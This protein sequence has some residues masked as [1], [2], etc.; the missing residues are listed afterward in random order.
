MNTTYK[1]QLEQALIHMAGITIYRNILNDEIVKKYSE[2]IHLLNGYSAAKSNANFSRLLNCYHEILSMLIYRYS[3]DHHMTG[4]LWKMHIIHL[5]LSDENPFSLACEKAKDFNLP[6]GL[7]KIVKMDLRHI[8]FLFNLDGDILQTIIKSKVPV[9]TLPAWVLRAY[10][11]FPPA[12]YAENEK[13]LAG[14]DTVH[15]LY[16]SENWELETDTLKTYYYQFGCGIFSQYKAFRWNQNDACG[17]LTGIDK[18]DPIRLSQL[19]SYERER[20]IVIKNTMQFIHGLPCNNVLLYGDR[21][22]GKSATVKA[23]LN[24]YADYRL[25]LIEVSKYHL[26]SLPQ[27]METLQKRGL[28]FILFIDD[29]SFE[30]DESSYRELKSI[31][32]G[33]IEVKPENVVIYA[34]SNRR[35]LIKEYFSERSV[36]DE[37]SSRDTM[38]EKLSLS[39]RFGITV[40]FS[41]PDKETYLQIVEGLAKKRGLDID[42]AVLR[43]EALKWEMRYNGRSPRTASQFINYLEGEL[44]PEK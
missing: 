1:K 3:E 9:D 5:L 22:T 39:D 2:L 38:Q 31:L 42:T 30:S 20:S 44:K 12:S 43:A 10:N 41:L 24:E 40:T 28:R 15:V 23:I 36:T 14:F 11:K 29:L 27:I 4:D 6:E 8:Q 37:V 17:F 25:R 19:I 13:S 21:G 16:C 26:I 7:L 18:P 32:E 34:T 33:G 35:H